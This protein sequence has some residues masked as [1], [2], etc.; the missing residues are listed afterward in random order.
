MNL[1]LERNHEAERSR[2]DRYNISSSHR[3][4]EMKPKALSI[5]QTGRIIQSS[6][7]TTM[8]VNAELAK[9]VQQR[10]TKVHGVDETGPSRPKARQQN[11][12]TNRR[13]EPTMAKASKNEAKKAAAAAI[14]ARM[15][16]KPPPSSSTVPATTA[17][18]KKGKRGFKIPFSKSKV[19][20]VADSS[21]VAGPLNKTEEEI[22]Q[23]YSKMM[24][25]G[26]PEGAVRHKMVSDGVSQK[27]VESVM[28]GEDPSPSRSSVSKPSSNGLSNRRAT[29]ALSSGEEKMAEKYRKMIKV[30]MPEG[31]VLHKMIADGVP[32]NIRIVV[33]A[34]EE[35][36][37]QTAAR[38]RQNQSKPAT[39]GGSRSSLS[40][41]EEKIAAQYRRMLRI[42]MPEG[43]VR[44]KMIA[45]G[46][47]PKIQDSVMNGEVSVASPPPSSSSPGVPA[48]GPVSSLSTE[49]ELVAAPYR[50]MIRMKM[51]EGAVRHKMNIDGVS[52]TIQDSVLGGEVPGTSSS[53]RPPLSSSRGS[54]AGPVSS[55]SREDELVAA[56]YR[57]MIRMKMPEGAVRHKMTIDCVPEPIQKS[58]LRGEIPNE[59]SQGTP[60]S[61]PIRGPANPMAA[62]INSSGGIGSLKKSSENKTNSGTVDPPVRPPSNPMAAMI[63]KSDGIKSLKKSSVKEKKPAAATAPS[64]PLTAAIAASGGKNGLKK[65]SPKVNCNLPPPKPSS[66]NSL[67]DE[68]SSKGF[69][70]TLR[71][72]T[73]PQKSNCEPSKLSFCAAVG[74]ELTSNGNRSAH[75]KNPRSSPYQSPDVSNSDNLADELDS[76]KF[77]VQKE[78]PRATNEDNSRIRHLSGIKVK[79]VRAPTPERSTNKPIKNGSPPQHH[80]TGTRVRSTPSPPKESPERR[81]NKNNSSRQRQTGTKVRP[82]RPQKES[83]ERSTNE[84]TGN[85]RPSRYSNIKIKAVRPAGTPRAVDESTENSDDVSIQNKRP[86]KEVQYS[87][88]SIVSEIQEKHPRSV[89][90]RVRSRDAAFLENSFAKAVHES[91]RTHHTF[92]TADE[93]ARS[94]SRSKSRDTKQNELDRTP[95]RNRRVVTTSDGVDHHC[96]CIVM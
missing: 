7:N 59:N 93:S 27:I 47:S 58:V 86:P 1:A 96:Q 94:G 29:S 10:F 26:L 87:N 67:L 66:G 57:R 43:A 54:P 33:M 88:S 20:A 56:P 25:M 34:G 22:A 92:K 51:P 76:D 42:K 68:L 38:G 21:T 84:N 69:R 82:P 32:A 30:G 52:Q 50:K 12:R 31:A 80:Q 11:G 74:E 8:D 70:S 40:P 24:K 3:S 62:A 4:R 35:P 72:T 41:P 61:P 85:D 14:M 95:R 6:S 78:E 15:G 81:T 65:R 90:S 46:V 91:V 28:S 73:T 71:K 23:K 75:R 77:Q 83:P 39:T 44:H 55:L 2:N 49:D 60:P 9:A 37:P 48:A 5:D 89:S 18:E 53:S 63:A 36:S 64:N 19:S 45:D 16:G 79:A 17:T 13:S